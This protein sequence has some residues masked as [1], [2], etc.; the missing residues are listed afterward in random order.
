MEK[1]ETLYHCEVKKTFLGPSVPEY[2]VFLFHFYELDSYVT[3]IFKIHL[4]FWKPAMG[5]EL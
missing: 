4:E 5:T 1:N 2:S 3:Q